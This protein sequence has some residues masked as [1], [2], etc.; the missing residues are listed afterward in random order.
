[1]LLP[2]PADFNFRWI[3]GFLAAR[4][5]PS[6]ER[7]TDGTYE[8]VVWLDDEALA[9]PVLLTVHASHVDGRARGEPQLKVRATPSVPSRVLRRAVVRMFDLDADLSAFRARARCDPVLGPVVSANPR[10]LRLPQLLDP[11]EALIRA[12][13]GQQVSVAAA[14][15]MTDRLVRLLAAPAPGPR[16]PD[17]MSGPRF[18]FPRAADVA[19]AGR[20]RLASIGL[21]RAKSATLH[22]AA[23][24]VATGRVDFALLGT[25]P[26]GDVDAA[27][28][29][30]PGIGPW[31][32][33][34]LRMRALG[35]RDAFPAADLGVI[36][37]LAARGV[38]VKHIVKRAEQWRP[39]RAYATL[40]LWHSLVA[41]SSTPRRNARL[42]RDA[43][44]P[45]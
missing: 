23:A 18:A 30:L 19:E 22:T 20:A 45:G 26:P 37:A 5:V 10:G 41:R 13:L 36:K 12:I 11:F 2:L 32:A 27:L 17:A 16:S 1:M 40:H 8:R 35:D 3:M 6:L 38:G 39:W 44:G 7:V 21:T 14:S 34:Y 43:S 42:C 9:R 24:A 25:L 33:A 28:C 15:T 31:T 4:E 29:A